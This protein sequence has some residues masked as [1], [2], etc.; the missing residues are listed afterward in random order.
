MPSTVEEKP[1]VWG[2]WNEPTADIP[3]EPADNSRGKSNG[4]GQSKWNNNRQINWLKGPR[5]NPNRTVWAKNRDMRAPPTD[6]ESEGGCDLKS[7]SDGDPDYDIK[8]LIDWE[9][10]W[11]PAGDWA[12]R[13]H[14][15]DRHFGDRIEEWAR[16]IPPAVEASEIIV[17]EIPD[18]CS[19]NNSALAPIWWIPGKIE[20]ETP[21]IF[22]GTFASRAPAPVDE[23]DVS[24]GPWWETYVD[25]ENHLLGPLEVPDARVDPED[26]FNALP[27]ARVNSNEV[28]A[29]KLRAEKARRDKI[30]AKRNRPIQDSAGVRPDADQLP[31]VPPLAP[32]IYL[33]LRPVRA[34]D[35]DQ[36]NAIYNHYVAHT[37]LANEFTNRKHAQMLDRINDI[38]ERGLPWIVAV[39]KAGR[40][41]GK[42]GGYVAENIV[43]FANIDDFCDQGS[44]YRYT[45]EMEMYV[46]PECLGKGVGSCIMDKLLSMV[47]TGYDQ[48]GGYEW[49]P[50]EN[51]LKFGSSRVTK[52]V[53]VTYPHETYE[54]KA[55]PDELQKFF[56]FMDRYG[57][58]HNARLRK[59]G[60][61]YGK[62]VDVS[63]YQYETT[64]TIDADQ[65]PTIPL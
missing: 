49:R 57:F 4:L 56:R 8:K 38:V 54:G 44:M 33:Y 41:P 48:R 40:T 17:N 65:R 50:A 5:R 35:V 34:T 36:I 12:G 18:F 52:V 23:G 45:F 1:I 29:R 62:V 19:D 28:V 53:N 15:A 26:T 60:F 16:S 24:G 64:E 22:W 3:N 9:G 2:E 13:K 21:R 58:K 6:D 14:F 43:G 51:Y 59:V 7:H 46:H 27:G 47:A 39:A 25:K 37:V 30:M 63:I 61:K 11:L 32:A 42:Y 55:R 10:N 20:G 31:L